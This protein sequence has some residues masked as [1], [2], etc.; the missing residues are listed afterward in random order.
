MSLKT[1]IV[2]GSALLVA[3]SAPTEAKYSR[4]LQ[5]LEEE[6][7]Q[8]HPPSHY[9]WKPNQRGF[10]QVNHHKPLTRE[11]SP[12]SQG[13]REQNLQLMDEEE[14]SIMEHCSTLGY[15]LCSKLLAQEHKTNMVI[16]G[17]M[18]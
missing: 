16:I 9:H 8:V 3:F 15:E 13:K 12:P 18:R 1:L 14:F 4:P 10:A 11:T 17:N 5:L 6:Y 2:L 7:D